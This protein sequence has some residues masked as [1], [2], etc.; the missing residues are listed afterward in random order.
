[1]PSKRP[2]KYCRQK[3]KG[4]ADRAFVNI[5]GVRIMLGNY[6]IGLH[7]TYTTDCHYK[8]K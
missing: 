3:C 4:R 2:P 6:G 5:D 8:E 1:M 7:Y